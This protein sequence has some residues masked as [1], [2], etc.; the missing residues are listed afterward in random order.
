MKKTLLYGQVG[1]S[2]NAFIGD[3]HRMGIAFDGRA[4]LAAG[5]FSR[6]GEANRSTGTNLTR[7]VERSLH[8]T[9]RENRTPHNYSVETNHKVREV[10]CQN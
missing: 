3:V 5:C 7:Q 6:D 4:F 9:T 8:T 2:L 10:A 1:G